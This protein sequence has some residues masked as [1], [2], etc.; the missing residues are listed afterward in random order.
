[1]NNKENKG[2]SPKKITT[3]KGKTQIESNNKKILGIINQAMG[4]ANNSSYLC[5]ILKC[6]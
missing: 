4:K 3:F 1:M 6:I 2:A 5:K